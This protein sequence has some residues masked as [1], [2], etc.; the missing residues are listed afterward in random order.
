MMF[1]AMAEWIQI[2]RFITGTQYTWILSSYSTVTSETVE[3]NL[4]PSFI[5]WSFWSTCVAEVSRCDAVWLDKQSK[6][7]GRM[8]STFSTHPT[9]PIYSALQSHST[10]SKRREAEMCCAE[11]DGDSIQRNGQ[12]SFKRKGGKKPKLAR[13][14]RQTVYLIVLNV[15]LKYRF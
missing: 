13:L 1:S 14:R 8:P 7:P 10:L 2:M 6:L 11:N 9:W 5:I 4:F 15:G 12:T 3:L